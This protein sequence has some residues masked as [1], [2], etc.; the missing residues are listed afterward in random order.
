MLLS[1]KMLLTRSYKA[2]TIISKFWR[3]AKTRE[4]VRIRKAEMVAA[5][6]R[7][8]SAWRLFWFLQIGP[9]IR[10]K[11]FFGAACMLQKYMRGYLYKKKVQKE[12]CNHKVD[13]CYNHFM[14]LRRRR[15]AEA[16]LVLR[17][18]G[19]KYFLK[20]KKQIEAEK[21]RK[22]EI[23]RKKK[24]EA[25]RRAKYGFSSKTKKKKT[26]AKKPAKAKESTS[27]TDELGETAAND[28]AEAENDKES[29]EEKA[30]SFENKSDVQTEKGDDDDVNERADEAD[31]TGA[32]HTLEAMHLELIPTA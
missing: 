21:A 1:K 5:A 8:Q 23:A 26:A 11:K 12:L 29:N 18:Y 16:R 28:A 24:E 7:I 14:E 19:R 30:M 6:S 20:R 27:K 2:A 17:Y 9:R 25:E 10:K 31:E 32:T 4:R 3:G 22:A 13:Y 15:E